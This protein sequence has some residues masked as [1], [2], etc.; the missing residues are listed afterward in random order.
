MI[1]DSFSHNYYKSL[2]IYRLC[3]SHN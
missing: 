3:L 1:T 2:A